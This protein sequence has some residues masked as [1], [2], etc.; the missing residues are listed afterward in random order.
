MDYQILGENNFD[1]FCKENSKYYF[2]IANLFCVWRYIDIFLAFYRIIVNLQLFYYF[3][4][5]FSG[6]ER[7]LN[8][9][10]YSCE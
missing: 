8:P 9:K 7:Y 6:S 2:Q 3:C 10:G 1:I 5:L 4:G